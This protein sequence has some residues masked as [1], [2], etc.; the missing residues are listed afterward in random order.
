MALHVPRLA[1][2]LVQTL[3]PLEHEADNLSEAYANCFRVGYN[4]AEFIMDFG[5][6]FDAAASVYYQR[7][8][9]TPSDAKRLCYLLETSIAGFEEKFGSIPGDLHP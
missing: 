4:S 9:T 7:I 5:R 6:Q 8:I 3:M 1:C 2:F